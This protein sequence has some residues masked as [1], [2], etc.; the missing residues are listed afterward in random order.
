VNVDYGTFRI[1]NGTI[2]GSNEPN[3]ALRNT[4]TTNAAL[5]VFS[6]TVEYGTFN[7]TTWNSKGS[8]SSTDNTIKV[9]NG[10]PQP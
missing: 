2:F 7:G 4:A 3:T 1:V 5:S 6:S 10:V 8:L 9:V